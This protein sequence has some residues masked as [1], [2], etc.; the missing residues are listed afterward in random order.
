MWLVCNRPD[1]VAELL[2]RGVPEIE[3]ASRT[4]LAALGLPA[5]R[6]W[7]ADPFAL[8]LHAPYLHARDAVVALAAADAKDNAVMA[9]ATIGAERPGSSPPQS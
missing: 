6:P 4:R 1:L 8:E 9:A 3:T 7:L 2:E 5:A